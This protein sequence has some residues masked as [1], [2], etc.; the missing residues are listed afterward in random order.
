MPVAWPA[1]VRD[2]LPVYT[3]IKE[4]G[5]AERFGFSLA[6]MKIEGGATPFDS[7]HT[8]EELAAVEREDHVTLGTGR[9]FYAN[10]G[11]IGLGPDGGVSEG[12]DGGVDTDKFT[13][14]ERRELAEMMIARWRK[15]GGID[16]QA[17]R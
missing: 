3:R 1:F 11:I 8:A 6:P 2:Y 9:R 14:D 12:L 5:M 10:R 4:D 7:H 13:P 16:G 15:F 17:I